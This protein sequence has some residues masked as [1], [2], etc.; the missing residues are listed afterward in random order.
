L[1]SEKIKVNRNKQSA[2]SSNL[3][4]DRGGF[5]IS[6]KVLSLGVMLLGFIMIVIGYLNIPVLTQVW[7]SMQSNNLLVILLPVLGALIALFTY[8]SFK[9]W[10]KGGSLQKKLEDE[11]GRRSKV[12]RDLTRAQ[13]ISKTGNWIL[14]LSSQEMRWSNEVCRILDYIPND[15]DM[16]LQNFLKFVHPD[17]RS[18]VEKE[19]QKAIG[20]GMAF[21]ITHRITRGDGSI[22]IVKQ[23]SEI[24]LDRKGEATRI[25]AT[26]QDITDQKRVENLV[27]DLGRIVD[28]SFNEIYTFDADTL[29]FTKVNLA[30]RLNLR[31]GME[32][33]HEMTLVDLN[34]EYTHEQFE[35]K[36]APLKRGAGSVTVFE[37]VHKRK[38]GT[39]YPV[40]V[41][42][43]LSINEV[44]PQFVAIVQD[45]SD[46][47]KIESL[48]SRTQEDFDKRL[49]E[50][51]SSLT[52][53]NKDLQVE[54]DGQKNIIEALGASEKRLTEILNNA[55]DGIVTVD[56]EGAI[57]SF[58]RAA[59]HLFGLNIEE[60]LGRNVNILLDGPDGSYSGEYFKNLLQSEKPAPLGL[61]YMVTARKKEG[62][63]F[64]AELTVKETVIGGQQMFIGLIRNLTEKEEFDHELM[65]SIK[66]KKN[67]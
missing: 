48:F 65:R 37:T 47:K 33:L 29:K 15:T 64:S 27:A 35:E 67:S 57:H 49:H 66:P 54:I 39:L 18:F 6:T 9:A 40:D 26:L 22:R 42:L 4:A 63:T 8:L 36:I 55:V 44:R 41:R 7:A 50:R 2:D 56:T 32:E 20:L 12:E 38:N 53:S 28:K 14:E 51:T 16:N 31:Y 25:L 24:Y 45:I 21:Y 3:K 10:R 11:V 46:R 62:T 58:N 1:A 19:I 13:E 34:P 17:D 5:W 23:R 59:E 52:K 30:A 43:Q 61:R 60:A